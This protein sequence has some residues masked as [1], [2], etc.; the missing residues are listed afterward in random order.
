L[1]RNFWQDTP[2]SER[3]SR[4]PPYISPTTKHHHSFRLIMAG[5]DLGQI[6]AFMDTDKAC[7]EITIQQIHCAGK[8]LFLLPE[9]A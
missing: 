8:R 2:D 3:P 1:S 7:P 6:G 4:Y 9:G 5:P